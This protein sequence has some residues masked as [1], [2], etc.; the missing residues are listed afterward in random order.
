MNVF[1][2]LVL[3]HVLPFLGDRWSTGKGLHPAPF[4]LDPRWGFAIAC[5]W[6]MLSLWRGTQL[7]L[8]AIRSHE[9][10]ARAIPI[11]ADAA[12]HALLQVRRGSG[13]GRGAELCASAE[14]ERPSVFGFFHPR[15]LLPSGLFEQL[16]ASDLEQVVTHEIEHLRR[17]DNWTN[18]LQKA[19]LVLIP[20]NPVLLWVE[21]RLCAEREHACDDRVLRST[22]ARKAY[23]ICLT[24]LAEY[25]M[26]RRELL[27]ALGAWERRSELVRRIHRILRSPDQAI[28]GK[29]MTLVTCSLMIAASVGALA[30]ARS[31][32]LL[33]FAPRAQLTMQARFNTASGRQQAPVREFSG[34]PELVKAVMPQPRPQTAYGVGH[35]R[36]VAGKRNVRR[37]QSLPSQTAWVVLTEWRESEPPPRV[38]IAVSQDRSTSYAAV[39]LANGWLI[40]QI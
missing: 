11:R 12:L 28:A 19:A 40:V 9:I 37:P 31:P 30:L 5:A 38:I 34:S 24:R 20:L 17:G 25:S 23:A 7:I 35:R 36:P 21:H 14:I 1:L 15:I 29:R 6:A 10:A 32:Q 4:L 8:S 22:G 39:P 13:R 2:L 18:L 3:L 16:A 27:L 33:S 26:I